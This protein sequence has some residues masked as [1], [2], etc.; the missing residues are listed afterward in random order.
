MAITAQAALPPLMAMG[1]ALLQNTEG[2]PSAWT[3]PGEGCRVSMVHYIFEAVAWADGAAA[4]C[5]H[6]EQA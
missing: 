6:A 5:G 3:R 2:P 4:R 1:A